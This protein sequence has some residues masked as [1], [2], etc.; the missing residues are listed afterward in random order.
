MNRRRL[1]SLLVLAGLFTVA[2]AIYLTDDA[3]SGV[4]AEIREVVAESTGAPGS[5]LAENAEAGIRPLANPD[6]SDLPEFFAVPAADG[7]E[8]IA[9]SDGVLGSCQVEGLV[10]TVTIRDDMSTDAVPPFVYGLVRP[11]V[12][13][14]SVDVGRAVLGATLT[15]GFYVLKLPSPGSQVAAVTFELA[16]GDEVTRRVSG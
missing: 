12:R 3:K 16:N 14:V 8:C 1:L 11:S 10:G 4:P 15:D 5:P 7:G 13:T 6:D 2:A 9:T